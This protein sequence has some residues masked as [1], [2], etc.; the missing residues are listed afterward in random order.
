MKAQLEN[1]MESLK[2]DSVFWTLDWLDERQ[3]S[4]TVLSF[5]RNVPMVQQRLLSVLK[6]PLN[7]A[8]LGEVTTHPEQTQNL[9]NDIWYTRAW[10]DA[11][12]EVDVGWLDSLEHR[13]EEGDP[14]LQIEAASLHVRGSQAREMLSRQRLCSMDIPFVY[15]GIFCPYTLNY[16]Q[17][18]KKPYTFYM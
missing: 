13:V 16:S 14:V 10:I 18:E 6:D 2:E 9:E 17:E 15:P 4:K 12:R 8:L 3:L 5:S 7:R 1:R 11:D